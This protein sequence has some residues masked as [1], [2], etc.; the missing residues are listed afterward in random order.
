[1]RLSAKA[2]FF[3]LSGNDFDFPGEVDGGRTYLRHVVDHEHNMRNTKLLDVQ[4][5]A[6]LVD[7]NGM[8]YYEQLVECNCR[9][10]GV[11]DISA[12]RESSSLTRLDL[13]NLSGCSPPV[14]IRQVVELLLSD[15]CRLKVGRQVK[16]W[17]V[18]LLPTQC[19]KS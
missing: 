5:Q 13:S 16:R 10:S 6:D 1:M 14:L 8:Q 2:A 9:Q 17:L 4:G 11:K 3:D 19:L 12:L 15:Q 7:L 18:L